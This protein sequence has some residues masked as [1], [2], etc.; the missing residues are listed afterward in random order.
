MPYVLTVEEVTSVPSFIQG[1]IA[2]RPLSAAPA[3][4]HAFCS[5]HV[6]ATTS[7]PKEFGV[8]SVEPVLTVPVFPVSII[9][10][11]IAES[12]LQRQLSS[13]ESFAVDQLIQIIS[14]DAEF[15]SEGFF[16]FAFRFN[17]FCVEPCRCVSTTGGCRYSATCRFSH[18]KGAARQERVNEVSKQKRRGI[19]WSVHEDSAPPF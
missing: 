17:R 16:H 9:T 3:G 14:K 13:A 15:M 19:N 5:L 18:L 7:A 2:R 12:N 1:F 11:A 4:G 10:R 6:G 8:C